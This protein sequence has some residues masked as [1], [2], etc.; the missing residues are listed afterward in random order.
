[1]GLVVE[2]SIDIKK[3]N[4]VTEIKLFLSELAEEFNCESYYYIYETEGI[5]C[6]IE[7]NDCIQVVEFNTPQTELEKN[8]ILNFI[9]KIINKKYTKLDT[10]YQDNGKVNMIYNSVNQKSD[11]Q[12]TKK[13]SIENKPIIAII[14]E[15]LGY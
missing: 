8:N 7:R 1:M 11:K 3:N 13:R 5:N 14:K 12:N 6:K 9:K 2:I 15:N 10:V 4:Q